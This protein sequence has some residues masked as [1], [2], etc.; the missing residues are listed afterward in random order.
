MA[1]GGARPGAGRKKGGANRLTEKAI[2][3]ARAGGLMPLD[4]L[5]QVLRDEGNDMAT[6]IDA[7]K[8]AAPYVHPK[9]APVDGE[10]KDAG[11]SITVITGVPR[12]DD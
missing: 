5:L 12:G 6:R 11:L 2:E 1:H 9:R 3:Q 8:A 4:Y 10:G 7:A